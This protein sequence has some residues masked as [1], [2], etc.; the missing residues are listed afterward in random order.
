MPS[1]GGAASGAAAGA[2]LGSAIPIPGLGTL[3]GA[4]VGA[5]AGGLFGGFGTKS[6]PKPTDAAGNPTDPGGIAAKALS[7]DAASKSKRA[8]GL[9]GEGDEAIRLATDF[10]KRM[11]GGDPTATNPV[12]GMVVDQYDTARR[13]AAEFAGRGGGATAASA[14][15]RVDEAGKISDARSTGMTEGAQ[16]LAQIGSGEQQLALSADQLASMDLNSVMAH[17]LGTDQLKEQ[18]GAT[19]SGQISQLAQG[20]GQLLGLYLTRG[21]SAVNVNV[22]APVKP[23][24]TPVK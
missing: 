12:V 16:A 2:A 1:W 19:R 22:G 10:F 4:G 20:I 7:A 5:L 14:Q 3:A 13:S 24:I 11:S 23:S 15:S 18:H 17:A 6:A 21:K 8:D 9:G